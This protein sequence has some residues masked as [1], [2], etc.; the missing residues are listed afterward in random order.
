[1]PVSRK[2]VSREDRRWAKNR[3]VMRRKGEREA[4]ARLAPADPAVDTWKPRDSARL[5]HEV[6]NEV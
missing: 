6:F 2:R 4:V 5:L 1:M 3:A